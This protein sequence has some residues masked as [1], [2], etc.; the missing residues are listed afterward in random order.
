MVPSWPA[1][2][3]AS[4]TRIICIMENT[5]WGF[6]GEAAFGGY[7]ASVSITKPSRPGTTPFGSSALNVA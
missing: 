6:S 7:S 5:E 3:K 1:F 2:L 4:I